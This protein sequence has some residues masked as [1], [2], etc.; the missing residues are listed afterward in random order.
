MKII[1]S[2][3]GGEEGSAARRWCVE[4]A[5]PGDEIIAVVGVDQFSEIM[6]SMSPLLDV[7]DPD[8][9]RDSVEQ[10]YDHE[11]ASHG[12]H[13]ET[14][15]T[16]HVQARAVD[17]TARAEDADLIVVGKHPRAAL[18]DA[19]H[20]ETALHLIH[21]PPCPVVVVPTDPG[22]DAAAGA[23]QTSGQAD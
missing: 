3:D 13:C 7:A 21:R 22:P 12:V 14:R 16:Y 4:H 5:Q 10:R 6:V 1:V 15:L 20:N 17:E 18:A 23:G 19:V 11:V 8:R 9:L 2:A